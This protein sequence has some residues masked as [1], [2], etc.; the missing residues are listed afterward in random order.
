MVPRSPNPLARILDLELGDTDKDVTSTDA[1][2][3][4]FSGVKIHNDTN[5]TD[6]TADLI[7][8]VVRQVGSN[9]NNRPNVSESTMIIENNKPH[10]PKQRPISGSSMEIE[11]ETNELFKKIDLS[12]DESKDEHSEKE[13][14]DDESEEKEEDWNME[15]LNL[16]LLKLQP[17]A[18]NFKFVG[19]LKKYIDLI[20]EYDMDPF[21]DQFVTVIYQELAKTGTTTTSNLAKVIDIFVNSPVNIAMKLCNFQFNKEMK[22]LNYYF[23]SW[24]IKLNKYLNLEKSYMVWNLY[25]KKKVFNNWIYQYNIVTIDYEQNAVTFN[26][27]KNIMNAFN[28]WQNKMDTIKSFNNIA[29]YQQ[30]SKFFNKWK[31]KIISLDDDSKGVRMHNRSLL[32]RN[33]NQWR[34]MYTYKKFNENKLMTKGFNRWTNQIRYQDNLRESS[35][36]LELVLHGGFVFNKWKIKVNDIIAKNNELNEI[37]TVYKKVKFFKIWTDAM[38]LKKTENQVLNQR[39]ALISRFII[40]NWK[41]RLTEVN[42]SYQFEIFSNNLVLKKMFKKWHNELILLKKLDEFHLEKLPKKFFKRW[43]LQSNL[44]LLKKSKMQSLQNNL[45]EKWHKK[46][47]LNLNLRK[48]EDDVKRKIL[49]LFINKVVLKENQLLGKLYEFQSFKKNE[50]LNIWKLKLLKNLENLDK[51]DIFIERKF[52]NKFKSSIEWNKTLND[53]SQDFFNTTDSKIIKL[54]YFRKFKSSYENKLEEKL[55]QR[56]EIY[57]NDRSE[58]IKSKMLKLWF[59]KYKKYIILQDQFVDQTSSIII[60]P[61]FKKMINKYRLIKTLE[62]K[63]NEINN[64]NLLSTGFTKIQLRWFKI[65]ELNFHLNE[66]LEEKELNLIL[67]YLNNW[68]LKTMKVKRDNETIN[69]FRKRWSRARMRAI[70]YLWR[71]KLSENKYVEDEENVFDESPV[72]VRNTYNSILSTPKR[73]SN[74][75]SNPNSLSIP[76]SERIKNRR[77]EALKQH[78]NQAKLAIPSPLVFQKTIDTAAPGSSSS[79]TTATAK[80]NFSSMKLPRFSDLGDNDDVAGYYYDDDDDDDES[81]E[82][83]VISHLKLGLHR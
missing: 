17:T 35:R 62:L 52:F 44:K 29:I 82:S 4:R 27:I 53:V 69:N 68:S 46:L 57:L 3:R 51:V 12:I 76:G 64:L 37:Y 13:K 28:S 6:N 30:E 59:N 5:I 39:G 15:M 70:L 55:E 22:L 40:E 45:F 11:E 32:R 10:R 77:I 50:Y 74:S 71:N 34:L 60:R 2:L 73:H 78:Y 80:L 7:N 79:T 25:L 81:I 42:Q 41:S 19:I 1:L 66:L 33:F 61:F 75:N 36:L 16:L 72:R 23:K 83:P 67:K 8:T 48:F 58:Y 18:K 14:E 56:L 24:L 31:K 26:N 43:R 9:S 38:N 47:L 21:K 65:Q 49:K 63:A 54:I 20:F